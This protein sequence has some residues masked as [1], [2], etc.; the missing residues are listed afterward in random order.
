[1][2]LPHICTPFVSG[3]TPGSEVCVPIFVGGQSVGCLNLEADQAYAI[4][5]AHIDRAA[6]LARILSVV[7]FRQS[8]ADLAVATQATAEAHI[9]RVEADD[10]RQVIDRFAAIL[11][12]SLWAEDVRIDACV[13]DLTRSQSKNTHVE[14]RTIRQ[15]TVPPT[16]DEEKCWNSWANQISRLGGN[17]KD[18]GDRKTGIIVRANPARHGANQNA[19]IADSFEYNPDAAEE[20]AVTIARHQMIKD[21]E[22]HGIPES[23]P[24]QNGFV[25]GMRLDTQIDDV[26]GSKNHKPTGII[27]MQY[28]PDEVVR[29]PVNLKESKPFKKYL[30]HLCCIGERA[31][32][33]SAIW[34]SRLREL[35]RLW[36]NLEHGRLELWLATLAGASDQTVRTA[37]Q[38]T[39]RA[40][41]AVFKDRDTFTQEGKLRDLIRVESQS[42]SCPL[43]VVVNETMTAAKCF[44]K[45]GEINVLGS[46]PNGTFGLSEIHLRECLSNLFV[47]ALKYSRDNTAVEVAIS[48][49]ED[50]VVISL[51][52]HPNVDANEAIAKISAAMLPRSSFSIPK[53]L[54]LQVSSTLAKAFG[55]PLEF[56]ADENGRITC[57]LTL[58]LTNS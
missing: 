56:I 22:D 2:C 51:C 21:A 35:E 14:I 24:T 20:D 5:E 47:N 53:K 17:A 6:F 16:I 1:M 8:V 28:A 30:Q 45:R 25:I 33:P 42:K 23:A 32:L 34:F 31:S 29:L 4:R 39:I 18:G 9:T 57:R 43:S 40:R 55:K 52:N 46:L 48:K 58:P 10:T 41:I 37:I 15:F 3:W 38:H 26:S 36:A 27:W 12:D 11:R 19:F 13:D 54:G 7:W 50:S 49:A 44:A